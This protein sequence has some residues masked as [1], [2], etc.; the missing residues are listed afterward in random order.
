MTRFLRVEPDAPDMGWLVVDTERRGSAV[1][2]ARSSFPESAAL[3]AKALNEWVRLVDQARDAIDAIECGIATGGSST[4]SLVLDALNYV[5]DPA[6]DADDIRTAVG[7]AEQT[8]LF[9]DDVRR[10]FD[11]LARAGLVVL[12]PGLETDADAAYLTA[13]AWEAR[14]T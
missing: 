4:L 7:V 3:V 12:V 6:A 9:G 11:R 14:T 5:A 1:V 8:G 13:A 10:A 2:V